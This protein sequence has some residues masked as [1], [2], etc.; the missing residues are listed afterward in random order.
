LGFPKLKSAQ[1]CAVIGQKRP[2]LGLNCREIVSD[3]HLHVT[4]DMRSAQ[5]FREQDDGV[6][7]I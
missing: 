3:R 4:L 2:I 7:G 5:L 1:A 6:A